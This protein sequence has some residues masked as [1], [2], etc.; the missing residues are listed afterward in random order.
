MAARCKRRAHDHLCSWNANEIA[1]NASWPPRGHK[2]K[3]R[4]N[5]SENRVLLDNGNRKQVCR[6]NED[7]TV[8]F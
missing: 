3:I 7:H 1:E 6:Q 5:E 4:E 8:I 2:K